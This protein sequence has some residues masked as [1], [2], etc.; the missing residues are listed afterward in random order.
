MISLDENAL[1][2]IHI[3]MHTYMVMLHFC[4]YL[5]KRLLLG[6]NCSVFY[7]QVQNCLILYQSWHWKI[8]DE[9]LPG[10]FDYL[11]HLVLFFLLGFI[12][13]LGCYFFPSSWLIP[14]LSMD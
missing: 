14:S 12:F 8:F 13:C 6:W 1:I 7:M 5:E 10:A 2:Y 4:L 3:Y 9:L 11:G